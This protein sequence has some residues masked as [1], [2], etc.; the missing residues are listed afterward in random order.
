MPAYIDDGYTMTGTIPENKSAHEAVR[1]EYRPATAAEGL[2]LFDRFDEIDA[3]E[4]ETRYARFLVDHFVSWNIRHQ[5]EPLEMSPTVCGRL[6]PS[7]RS[8]ML[9]MILGVDDG[10][11]VEGSSK[12]LSTE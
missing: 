6:A 2:R 12:N 1:F 10:D 4:K 7:L 5:G 3:E 11:C 9:D 8:R